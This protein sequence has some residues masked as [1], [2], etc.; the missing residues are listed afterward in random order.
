[1]SL[2]ECKEAICDTEAQSR[3]D[4]AFNKIDAI[5]GATV[6]L[7]VAHS[8]IYIHYLKKAA[9]EADLLVMESGE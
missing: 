1:M 6:D 3:L 5:T 7:R 8:E 4:N 2:A 9:K